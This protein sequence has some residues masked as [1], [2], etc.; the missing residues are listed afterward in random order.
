MTRDQKALLSLL[1]TAC[2]DHPYDAADP[3]AAEQEAMVAAEE[4]R[5]QLLR[6]ALLLEAPHLQTLKEI[7]L[8]H[9][10]RAE[11]GRPHFRTVG[12]KV[13]LAVFDD[14]VP[15]LGEGHRAEFVLCENLA[16][17]VLRETRGS[18]DDGRD[19]DRILG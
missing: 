3:S 12:P 5:R 9:Q 8:I 11:F 6:V 19:Q 16:D 15:G 2:T 4:L 1:S 18:W 17:R 10:W 13:A 14:L 7:D